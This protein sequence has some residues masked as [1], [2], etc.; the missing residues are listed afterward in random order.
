M[1]LPPRGLKEKRPPRAVSGE[2]VLVSD[3]QTHAMAAQRLPG[4]R[5][6]RAFNPGEAAPRPSGT[7]TCQGCREET[8]RRVDGKQGLARRST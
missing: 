8:A 6:G 3:G 1:L 2:K 4:R 5:R 7:P